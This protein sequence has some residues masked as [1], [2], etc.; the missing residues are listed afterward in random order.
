VRISAFPSFAGD[1]ALFVTLACCSTP[2]GS[3]K[4][5]DA[6]TKAPEQGDAGPAESP[7][8]TGGYTG[9]PCDVQ[10]VLENRCIACHDG[11]RE[12]AMLDYGDLVAPSKTEPNRQ[13]AEVAVDRMASATRPMPPPPASGFIGT[14]E[15]LAFKNWVLAGMP[16]NRESCTAVPPI[17][18]GDVDAATTTDA[19][20]D[21]NQGCTSGKYWTGNNTA[22]D[23]MHPGTACNACHQQLGGPNMRISGTVYPTLK[24]ADD[25]YGSAPP[26]ALEVVVLDKNGVERRMPVNSAGNFLTTLLVTAP[27]VAKVTDG[28]KTRT[29]LGTVTSG[30]CNSCHT[31]S[32]KNGAPGRILAP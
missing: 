13:L 25:C 30:D 24:E 9:L 4:S 26:P 8:G 28:T 3:E 2:Y 22:S 7:A 32:G 27:Y 23:L 19:G 17:G 12:V 16:K 6:G 18:P 15:I 14:D 31:R 10:A 5:P 11:I 1:A 29:M 21:A 20:A